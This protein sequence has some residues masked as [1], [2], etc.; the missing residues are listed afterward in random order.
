MVR[1]ISVLL[2]HGSATVRRMLVDAFEADSRVEAVASAANAAIALRKVPQL[3]PDVVLVDLDPAGGDPFATVRAIR[4][5]YPTL[6]VVVDS[7]QTHRGADMSLR[8]LTAGATRCVSRPSDLTRPR[9]AAR[10]RDAL[11]PVLVEVSVEPAATRREQVS[12]PRAEYVSRAERPT[13]R[14]L[15]L[16]AST[17]GPDALETVLTGL[18]ATFPLP[19]LVVQHMPAGF[20]HQFAQRLAGRCPL[21]VKEAGD[22]DAVVRGR[23]LLA[24]GGLHMR[25]SAQGEARA[26]HLDDGTPENFCRP[27]VDVLFRSAATCYGDGAVAV[28]LTGMGA[29]GMRGAAD[30]VAAG[31]EVLIQDEASST[32]WGM[33]GAV[34]KAGLASATLPLSGIAPAI[35]ERTALA[36]SRREVL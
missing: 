35:L 18:P 28:V 11:V 34:S 8:A 33:P 2:V 31:S 15:L 30:L 16:G 21:D 36:P 10:A 17:G 7:E 3:N 24:P 22:G 14:V 6:P 20:T 19:V 23:V 32:V 29:D 12:P 5:Q 27:S 26:V 13:P 9:Q 4:S 25:V 1:G